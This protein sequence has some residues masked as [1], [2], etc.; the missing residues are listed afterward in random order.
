[1]AALVYFLTLFN[2]FGTTETIPPRSLAFTQ[3]YGYVVVHYETT[4]YRTTQYVSQ[5]FGYCSS[6]G[7]DPFRGLERQAKTEAELLEGQG[8][9]TRPSNARSMRISLSGGMLSRESAEKSR[10]FWLK[11]GA[12]E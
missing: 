3:Y 10:E 4:S 2:S 8:Q 1:M 5:V 12:V 11:R 9:I 7:N 6:I